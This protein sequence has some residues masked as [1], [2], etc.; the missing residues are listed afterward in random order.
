MDALFAPLPEIT[1][2][3]RQPEKRAP[4][5]ISLVFT[6]VALAPLAGFAAAAARVGANLKVRAGGR[7]WLCSAGCGRGGRRLGEPLHPTVLTSSHHRPAQGFPT[8]GAGFVAAAGFHGGLAAICG[9][10]L[11]FW[12]KL[13]LMQTVPLLA[14]LGTATA[15]FG[16]STLRGAQ[17]GSKPAKKQD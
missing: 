17:P 9:L 1:H 4:V 7:V 12:V 16:G 6:A 10:Y 5:V 15:L 13:N 11:L 8:D 14:A 3:H 2:Q